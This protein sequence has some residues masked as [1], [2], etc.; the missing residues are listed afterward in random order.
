MF[1]YKSV[2]SIIAIVL[3]VAYEPLRNKGF[4]GFL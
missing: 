1:F 2:H 3:L 4:K